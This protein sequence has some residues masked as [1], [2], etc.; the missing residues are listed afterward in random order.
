MLNNGKY[1]N[2][3]W[4]DRSKATKEINRA[5]V[6]LV[7]AIPPMVTLWIF[8]ILIGFI[9]D[10]AYPAIGHSIIY[11][12]LLFLL[13]IKYKFCNWHRAMIVLMTFCVTLEL[14]EKNDIKFLEF[15]NSAQLITTIIGLTIFTVYGT[16]KS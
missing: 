1:K 8:L 16:R 9:S 11:N 7:Y 3:W 12:I 4:F 13:S 6:L 2:R 10:R 14:F 5:I 15:I